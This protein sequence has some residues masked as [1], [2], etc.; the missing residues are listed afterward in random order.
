[1]ALQDSELHAAIL[2]GDQEAEAELVRRFAPRIRRKVEASIRGA[3]DREDLSSEILQA[4]LASL[5]RGSFRGE[6]ALGTFVHAV[7]RNK[8]A[9]FLRR[10]RRPTVELPESLSD[11]APG[12]EE[13]ALRA[14][15][16]RAVNEALERLPPKYRQVLY[17]YYYEGL[18]ISE[19]AT[20]LETPPRRISERKDYA[21]KLIRA[22]YR[23]GPDSSSMRGGALQL[24]GPGGRACPRS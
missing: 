9:E 18:S 21:L 13:L 7:A 5:R 3:A 22:R 10:P 1:M 12:P 11:P 19:I 6:C 14:E 16:A 4:V 20:R 15:T 17:L 2:A 24:R 8:V 23:G